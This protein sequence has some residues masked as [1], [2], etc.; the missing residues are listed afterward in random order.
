MIGEFTKKKWDKILPDVELSGKQKSS[1]KNIMN[2][3]TLLVY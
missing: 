1:E 3:S 2:V